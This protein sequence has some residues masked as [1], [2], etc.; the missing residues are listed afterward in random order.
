[1][2]N[3]VVLDSEQH[4]ALL[5]KEIC[6]DYYFANQIGIVLKKGSKLKWNP[7]ILMHD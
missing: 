2:N 5:Y 4:F 3:M 7:L 1:M 6:A